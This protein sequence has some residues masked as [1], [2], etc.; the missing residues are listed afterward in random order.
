MTDRPIAFAPATHQLELLAE[1][2]ITARELL[3]TY[4]ARIDQF[5]PTYNIVVAQE[6]DGA[7]KAA[8]DVDR[9]RRRG[10]RLGRLAGLPMTIKDS[11]ETVGMVTTCGLVELKNHRP[12]RDAEAVSR[13]R[14]EGAVIFGKTNLPAGAADG[15]SV[16]P[17]YGLTSNPWNTDRTVGGSSGGSAASL[18]A[19]FT[20]LELGSDIA[21]SIRLPSHFCGVFG[22][23]PSYGIVS[24][25]GHIPPMPGALH[26]SP[27]SVVGP[28]ARSA[29]DLKLTLPVLAGRHT[30]HAPG[31]TFEL[32]APRKDRLADFRVAVWT[33]E[34]AF[35]V[36]GEYLAAV[37]A[38]VEH[39]RAAGAKVDQVTLPVDP[40]KTYDLYLNSLFALITAGRPQEAEALEAIADKDETGYARRFARYAR[41]TLAD[42]F[43]L[44][45]R[46]EQVFLA[47]RDFF[48]TY[49]VLLCPAATVV[50]HPHMLD[51]LG[52]H[53][54]QMPRRL[55]VSGRSVPY[56]HIF[57]WASIATIANL[58]ATVMPIWRLVQGLPA[59][60]QII[61]P[62]MEDLTPIRFA[63]LAE[64]FQGGFVPP[65]ALAKETR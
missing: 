15:Q 60:V 34:G 19:G 47:W 41:S 57:H 51:T 23:K 43:E 11:F 10:E 20:S 14:A 25:R 27:L 64:G 16:N 29:S 59:G 2:K 54:A 33:G 52:S 42:W 32:Q 46:R 61:G 65:P 62:H 45:E 7:R 8:D 37:H 31:Y 49:D 58:P 3:E 12:A 63:E 21:G 13:L 39:I 50:A 36:D 28:L 18:A 1:G 6:R 40:E 35:P 48:K 24:Q 4:F 38:F 44:E 22:H 56:F 55:T 17:V 26:E 9:R 5:N 30:L 53:S